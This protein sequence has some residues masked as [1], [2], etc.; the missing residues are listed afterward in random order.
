MVLV[1]CLKKQFWISDTYNGNFPTK[2]VLD[3]AG[4]DCIGAVLA[5][6]LEQVCAPIRI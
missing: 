2:L 1:G 5:D 3:F 4:F 6:E